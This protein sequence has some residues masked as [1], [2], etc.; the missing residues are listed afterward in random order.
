V[1]SQVITAVLLKI[2]NLVG[3]DIVQLGEWICDIAGYHSGIVED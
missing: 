3:C 2:Q 1:T